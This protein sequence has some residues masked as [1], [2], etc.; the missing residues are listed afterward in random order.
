MTWP[1]GLESLTFDTRFAS[2]A[3][4]LVDKW[5]TGCPRAL[6]KLSLADLDW[7]V[8]QTKYALKV[9]CFKPFFLVVDQ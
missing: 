3:D 1:A 2:F 4:I 6:R 9:R 8:E 7:C 5:P